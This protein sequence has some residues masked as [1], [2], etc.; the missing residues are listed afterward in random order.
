M[1]A[2]PR[3]IAT[4]T[5]AAWPSDGPFAAG[6][7][8]Q[9]FRRQVS[10]STS[11][12]ATPRLF[13]NSGPTRTQRA[14]LARAGLIRHGQEG[15]AGLRTHATQW[16][17]RHDVNVAGHERATVKLVAHERITS[18]VMTGHHARRPSLCKRD[19][20]ERSHATRCNRPARGKGDHL[21][22]YI[23]F[24]VRN[25]RPRGICTAVFHAQCA[26]A[27]SC[28]PQHGRSSALPSSQLS[29]LCTFAARGRL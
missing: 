27:P 26:I 6:R 24:S 21:T 12:T 25:P 13:I 14:D 17:R 19:A 8:M 3:G 4:I 10:N 28:P 9:S 15:R 5:R 29:A 23:V 1:T 20:Q 16:R 2:C 7:D 11:A 22:R 18:R